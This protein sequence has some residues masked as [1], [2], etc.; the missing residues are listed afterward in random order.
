MSET[1]TVSPSFALPSAGVAV[2]SGHAPRLYEALG[3]EGI[4]FFFRVAGG[5][6][7]VRFTSRGLS[8]GGAA[9]ELVPDKE[10]WRA[11]AP[12][13]VGGVDWVKVGARLIAESYEAGPYAPGVGEG[14]RPVGRPRRA[15]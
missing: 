7:V 9:L 4:Y 5:G 6:R 13:A 14:P 2:S 1:P 11:Y 12:V 8:K 15:A 10:H 3:Y